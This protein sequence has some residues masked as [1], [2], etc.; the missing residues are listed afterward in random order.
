MQDVLYSFVY[1]I[2]SFSSDQLFS[3]LVRIQLWLLLGSL[4]K[5][6]CVN[7]RDQD[8]SLFIFNVYERGG[9]AGKKY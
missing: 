6:I 9:W 2:V 4:F 3:G 5:E 7:C 1:I 8:I